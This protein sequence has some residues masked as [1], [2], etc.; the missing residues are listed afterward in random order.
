MLI[1]VNNQF[2]SR[3][4]SQYETEFTVLLNKV[5]SLAGNDSN[6][7][8]VLSIPDYYFTPY[9][10][11]NGNQQISTELD[12]YNYFAKSTAKAKGVTFLDITDITRKGL[13]E[14]ELVA[15]DGLHP[16]VLAYEKFVERLYPLVSTR[17]KD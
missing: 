9:G 16:S 6:K 1:G 14:M 17:L 5:I 7:V 10:Q 12:E 8:I 3:P 2:K 11:S 15:T 13:N 4:F